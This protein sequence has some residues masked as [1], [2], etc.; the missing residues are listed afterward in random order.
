MVANN[1]GKV[2]LTP[3]GKKKLEDE[4]HHLK[5][6]KR[7]EVAQFLADIMEEG[8]IS[9]NSG[10]DDARAKMGAVESRIHELEDLLLKA[11]VVE[12]NTLETETVTLG[13]TVVVED[14]AGKARTFVIVGTHEVDTLKGHISDE[15]PIGQALMGRRPGDRVNVVL[16]RGS[17]TF[18]VREV[19]FE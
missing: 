6:V 18:T 1:E 4:L 11:V 15:S 13:S 5:T 10:Y 3:R 16:P 7:D 19:R 9:E 14:A 2:V 12:E 8:D 17:A